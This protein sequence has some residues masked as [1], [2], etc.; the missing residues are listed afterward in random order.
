VSAL[1]F[2]DAMTDLYSGDA[3]D[4]LRG[5]P[6]NSV[7]SICTDPPYGLADLPVKKVTAALTQWMTGDRAFIPGG[8]GFMGAAWD[9]FVPP[10]ALWDE[11]YR[12]LKPGGYLL[13]F[14]GTRTQDLMGMSIRLAGFKI[15]DQLQWLRADSFAKTKHA[16]K[17]G[18]EPIIMAQKPLDGTIAHNI[19]VWGTGGLNIDAVRTAFRNEAD[20]RESK[21]KNK[22]GEYGTGQGGNTVF[23]DYSMIAPRKDYDAPGRWPTNILLDET[24]ARQIDAASPSSKS[25]KSAPRSAENGDGWRMTATGAEYDDEGGPSRFYP[26]FEEDA[27]PFFYAGR[28]TAKE[29]PVV[30]GVGHTTVKPLSVMSW[31]IRLIT[32]AGGIVLDPFA[33]SGTTGEAA[34][35]GGFRSILVEAHEPHLPLIVQRMERS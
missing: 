1:F 15:K 26:V 2:T 4:V 30:D 6:E 29:R 31:G 5:L 17:P 9:R 7:D 22:H 18:Y 21:D 33:G 16:L 35:L 27:A 28:A 19:E 14:A 10:P 32:P 12:V 23:G 8:Q 13:S 25:R 3:I 11:V 34:R 20:E 24:T